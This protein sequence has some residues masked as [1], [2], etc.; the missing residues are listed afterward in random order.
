[1]KQIKSFFDVH[2]ILRPYS[3]AVPPSA[4][5]YTLERMSHLMNYLGNPQ[6]TIK[7]IHVAGTSGKTSTSYYIASM[8]KLAGFRTGLTVSPH[9]TQVN[10]RVQIDLVPLPEAAYAQAFEAFMNIIEN[11]DVTPTYF[12]L[13][14]AFAYWVFAREKVDYAVV[15]VG[16]GGLLDSTNVASRRDKICVV[17]DIGLDH[18]QILGNSL[19]A[20]AAQKAGIIRPGNQVFHLKQSTTV[21][22]V[23][24]HAVARAGARGVVHVYQELLDE[25]RW[26]PHYQARNWQLANYVVTYVLNR[27]H[28]PALSK[29]LQVESMHTYIPGRMEVISLQEK[30]IVLDGAHNPQKMVALVDSM[31]RRFGEAAITVVVAFKSSKDIANSITELSK[32]TNQLIATTFNHHNMASPMEIQKVSTMPV[33]TQPTLERAVAAALKATPRIILFTGSLYLLSRV[34]TI[35]VDYMTSGSSRS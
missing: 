24:G 1:M 20:I 3:D 17:T 29:A 10:E 32:L 16:L 11:L 28:M 23:I 31:R 4:Q 35:L 14:V 21:N 27:E 33:R 12:E 30:T 19:A 18:Q 25:P 9:L 34:D 6:N 15:E 2:T 5:A 22:R 26:L 13:L 8:L 7:I